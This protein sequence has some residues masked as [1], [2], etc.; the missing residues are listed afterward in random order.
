MTDKGENE[1]DKREKQKWKARNRMRNRKRETQSNKRE[2]ALERQMREKEKEKGRQMEHK[3]D[4]LKKPKILIINLINHFLLE[5][6]LT[7]LALVSSF[8]MHP[9][10]HTEILPLLN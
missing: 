3:S 4:N 8:V 7:H 9:G 5:I 10:C 6:F 2:M 1:K